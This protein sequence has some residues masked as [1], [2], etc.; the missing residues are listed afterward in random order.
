MR[1]VPSERPAAGRASTWFVTQTDPAA[2]AIPAG[3]DPTGIRS[4]TSLDSGSMRETV[5]SSRFATHTASAP[6]A[7]PTG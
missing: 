7:M 4:T 2:K 1:S 5:P 6:T 3:R